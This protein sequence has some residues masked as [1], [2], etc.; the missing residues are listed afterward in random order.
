MED[1]FGC[2]FGENSFDGIA[3]GEVLDCVLIKSL[4]TWK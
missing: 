4:E 3:S 1:V 2:K